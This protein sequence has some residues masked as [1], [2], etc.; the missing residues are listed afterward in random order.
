[1]PTSSIGQRRASV[2]DTASR[3]LVPRGMVRMA[4][5]MSV[6]SLLREQGVDPTPLVAEFGLAPSHFDQPDYVLPYEVRSRLLIRCAE[7]A[8]CPHFGLLVG[9]RAG[10][11]SFGLV[12]FLVQ[13]AP[14]V[15]TALEAGIRYFPL[16]NPN[17]TTELVEDGRYARFGHTILAHEAAGREQIVD[18][19][20]AIIFNAMRV[21]CGHGG[22]P[23]EVRLARERPQDTGPYQRFFQAPL[24]FDA[25][26]TG[27]VIAASWLDR[28]LSTA[29]PLLHLMMRQRIDEL[30]SQAGEDVASRLRRMLPSL[31]AVRGASVADAARSLGIG[32]RTLNRRLA[33]AGTSFAELRS[34]ARYA[35]AR[36]LLR[37]T[38][39]P[40]GEIAVQLGYANASALTFAFR[41]WS[42][43]GPSQ[44]RAST[45]S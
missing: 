6:P 39:M 9:Q 14:D 1:M 13:S 23:V 11:S 28:P 19:A 44:W 4:P 8:G 7:A 10:L 29:D 26:D 3:T 43:M 30:A 21:L 25:T 45:R 42:G 32:V 40:V 27:L 36:Q 31:L 38:A 15:R 37:G 22:A 16:H 41:R 12:G 17:A 18:M 20:A 35:M 24:V 2:P 34:E 33:D 5:T